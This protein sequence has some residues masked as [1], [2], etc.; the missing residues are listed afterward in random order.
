MLESAT[1]PCSSRAHAPAAEA[2]SHAS[3]RCMSREPTAA[4]GVAVSSG[5][6]RTDEDP[7]TPPPEPQSHSFPQNKTGCPFEIGPL[8]HHGGLRMAPRPTCSIRG[9][10]NAHPGVVA[11]TTAPVALLAK[12][13]CG[14]WGWCVVGCHLRHTCRLCWVGGSSPCYVRLDVGASFLCSHGACWARGWGGHFWEQL[15]LVAQS[16]PRSDSPIDPREL[17]A[18]CDDARTVPHIAGR[19]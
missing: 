18:P 13:I 15:G 17:N 11:G 2:A 19:G 1:H 5:S 12:S 10:F 16:S 8:V 6:G 3:A 7:F 9:R 14:A 4:S